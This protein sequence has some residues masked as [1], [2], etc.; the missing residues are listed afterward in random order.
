MPCSVMTPATRCGGVMS[1]AGAARFGDIDGDGDL[2]LILADGYGN[3]G[4]PET[5]HFYVNDG[6]GVFSEDAG[7]SAGNIPGGSDID[8]A[9]DGRVN[10]NSVEG[11]VD[12]PQGPVA[13]SGT[14]VP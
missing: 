8:V 4:N 5:L 9:F 2:D 6:T 11:T 1:N 14:R 10:G 13:F 12:S 7:A 3:S